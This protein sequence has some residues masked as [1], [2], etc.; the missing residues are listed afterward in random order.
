[1]ICVPSPTGH[2]TR[3]GSYNPSTLIRKQ[4]KR[5][6]KWRLFLTATSPLPAFQISI[7]IAVLILILK[8]FVEQLEIPPFPSP[9]YLSFLLPE[10]IVDAI[11][12]YEYA[13]TTFLQLDKDEFIIASN[14]T[15]HQGGQMIEFLSAYVNQRTNGTPS[16]SSADL[17]EKIFRLIF[18]F[19]SEGREIS[20][21]IDWRFVVGVTSSWYESYQSELSALLVR[22]WRRAKSKM[23]QEF[24]RLRDYFIQSFESILLDDANDIIP[25]LTGLRYIVTLNHEITDILIDGDGEFLSVLH[26]H[27]VAYRAHLNELEREAILYLFYTVMVSLAYRASESSMGYSKKGKGVANSAENLFFRLFDKLFGEYIRGTQS[28]A[29][30]ED[31]NKE[32]P[33]GEIMTEWTAE[34]KGA[35]EAVEGLLLYLDRLKLEEPIHEEAETIGNVKVCNV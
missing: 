27:Y 29:F 24:S 17:D 16:L 23:N 20:N 35:D 31:I 8:S 2:E 13:V 30:I 19:I 26:D 18:R 9:N 32:T 15:T 4:Q 11:Y 14:I 12:V 7:A 21:W 25:A 3:H 6:R 5:G 28:D 34:W 1:M 10:E 22:V 33:F